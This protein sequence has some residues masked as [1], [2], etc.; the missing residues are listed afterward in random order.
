ME[1][2]KKKSAWKIWLYLIPVYILVAIPLVKWTMKIYSSDMNLSKE[3]YNAFNS[4]EGEVKKIA[5]DTSDPNLND[6]GY[7]L[8]Y[9]SSKA[10][11]P[12]GLA[13]EEEEESARETK[14]P[15]P[16]GR[17]QQQAPARQ[18]GQAA[19]RQAA[20]TAKE[21]DRQFG[22]GQ[23]KGLMTYAVGKAMGNPKAVGALFNSSYV[24]KGFM[25]RGTVK[26]ALGSPQGLQNYLK[27]NPAAVNN[28]LNNSVVQAAINNPAIVNAFAGSSMASSILASPGV[29][30]L[31]ADP[32]SLT[33]LA[34]SNPQMMQ[35]LSNP[36]VMNALTN[37]PQTAGLAASLG[38]GVNFPKK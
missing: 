15:G 13:E 26:G 36:N 24:V 28:F 2:E 5:A 38:G 4:D 9:R 16:A 34:S 20:V 1:E 25:G 21:A 23:Q 17:E 30:G 19:P 10:G 11:A 7:A 18:Q 31:L 35:L 6:S 22:L 3:D 14:R 37:N 33:S 12:V 8:H 29:Q 32:D 27:N